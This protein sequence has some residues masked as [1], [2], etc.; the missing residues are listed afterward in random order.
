MFT[1]RRFARNSACRDHV[2]RVLESHLLDHIASAQYAL[3]GAANVNSEHDDTFDTRIDLKLFTQARIEF[4]ERDPENA[5][6]ARA[7]VVAPL[8]ASFIRGDGAAGFAF[9]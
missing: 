5:S 6:A 9:F 2:G 1:D 8:G 3:I 4:R 7:A